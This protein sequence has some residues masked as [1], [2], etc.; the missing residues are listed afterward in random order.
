M[1][2]LNIRL[3]V[4][5]QAFFVLTCFRPS[6]KGL[7]FR[8]VFVMCLAMWPCIELA[9]CPGCS[10]RTLW[11]GPCR[12]SLQPWVQ[13]SWVS[14][15]DGWI[16]FSKLTWV[17]GCWDSSTR[18]KYKSLSSASRQYRCVLWTWRRQVSP[19]LIDYR[20]HGDLP[21][22]GRSSTNCCIKYPL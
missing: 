20:C 6:S 1:R 18:Q 9:T 22:M 3:F 8:K 11:I 13:E 16:L 4:S 12:P 21:L 19:P 15:I 5:T 17:N 2:I 7:H 10:F 14:L